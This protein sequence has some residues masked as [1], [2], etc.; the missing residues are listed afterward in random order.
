[1]D[2]NLLKE[3]LIKNKS[4]LETLEGELG[5][6][7][8]SIQEK[9]NFLKEENKLVSEFV[10]ANANK[11][12]KFNVSGQLFR[13]RLATLFACS[14]SIFSKSYNN[15]EI[16]DNIICLD[17]DPYYFEIILN[18]LRFKVID[19]ARFSTYEK[20]QLFN[21][22][23]Y[24]EIYDIV[25]KISDI[26]DSV[27]LKKYEISGKYLFNGKAIGTCRVEDL[28]DKSMMNGVCSTNTIIFHLSKLSEI[29]SI[30]IGGYKGHNAWNSESG[31]GADIS[32]STDK[33]TWKLVGSIPSEF[34]KSIK[35][36]SIKKEEAKYIKFSTTNQNIGI[37]YLRVHNHKN[38]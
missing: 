33:I 37:G 1:M 11:I 19:I 5:K 13:T 34:G 23:S 26:F 2:L 31:A 14:N 12:V 10:A 30:E 17:R 36:V 16:F 20:Q 27:E 3:D 38:F 8:V 18:Y 6:L 28:N 4:K 25:S 29:I 22:A 9:D 7:V 32:I 15:P 35:E 24:Y 21:E